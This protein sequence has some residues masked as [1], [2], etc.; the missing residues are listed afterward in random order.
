[1]DWLVS[2]SRYK[3]NFK[4]LGYDQSRIWVLSCPF[5]NFCWPELDKGKNFWRSLSQ[6]PRITLS[7]TRCPHVSTSCLL[8]WKQE[9]GSLWPTLPLKWCVFLLVPISLSPCLLI[10]TGL[11]FRPFPHP[12]LP[13][14]SLQWHTWETPYGDYCTH[15]PVHPLQ[16]D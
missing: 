16:V 9:V 15:P 14:A 7:H 13:L 10:F 11:P 3:S 5:E 6:M 1:M 8:S 4:E 2:I 12:P